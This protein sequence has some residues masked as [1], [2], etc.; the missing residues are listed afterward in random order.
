M[1]SAFVDRGAEH[2]VFGYRDLLSSKP[3]Y[4]G[5][6]RNHPIIPCMP[7]MKMGNMEMLYFLSSNSAKTSGL[8]LG[9]IS[10]SLCLLQDP[11]LLKVLGPG[12]HSSD[13]FSSGVG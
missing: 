9:P 3:C 8:L 7:L 11:G 6:F 4:D 13:L 5:T 1:I 10:G 12:G 2:L